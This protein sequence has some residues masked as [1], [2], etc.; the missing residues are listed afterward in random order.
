MKIKVKHRII[1]SLLR[2]HQF[3]KEGCEDLHAP[4]M[5][6][7]KS[8]R[9]QL[10][11][12]IL[13]ELFLLYL[14]LVKVIQETESNYSVGYKSYFLSKVVFSEFL[15]TSTFWKELA[16]LLYKLLLPFLTFVNYKGPPK[17][18]FTTFDH[19][20]RLCLRS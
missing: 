15:R 7:V 2:K 6:K 9:K 19:V 17:D 13:W 12:V 11:T 20:F 16:C 4:D 18:F 1:G 14:S 5:N 8:V 3:T 10:S